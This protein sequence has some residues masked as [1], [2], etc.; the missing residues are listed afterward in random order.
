M[1]S[2][3]GLSDANFLF[4]L[5]FRFDVFEPP[6]ISLGTVKLFA[7]AFIPLSPVAPIAQLILLVVI[8]VI[9]GMFIRKQLDIGA[10]VG[11]FWLQVTVVNVFTAVLGLIG[12][13]PVVWL[14]SYLAFGWGNDRSHHPLLWY[15]A[16]ILY[17]F[18]IPWTVWFLCYLISWRAE[19]WLLSRGEPCLFT[20]K[21]SLRMSVRSAHRLSYAMLAVPVII[22]TFWY[23]ITDFQLFK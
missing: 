12:V 3:L 1:R 4:F 13:L 15:T 2:K 14:E 10:G 22:A 16:C 8:I 17:G 19:F 9:E 6:H 7:D 23:W 11:S 20:D 5:S 21:T 18:A